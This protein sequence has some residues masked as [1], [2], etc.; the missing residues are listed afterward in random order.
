MLLV[1]VRKDVFI[2]N[3]RSKFSQFPKW[4]QRLISASLLFY[5]V[6]MLALILLSFLRIT[7]DWMLLVATAGGMVLLTI[8][9]YSIL[10]SK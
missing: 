3:T 7:P 8:V 5:G 2:V 1:V 4:E 6:V 10:E 9:K